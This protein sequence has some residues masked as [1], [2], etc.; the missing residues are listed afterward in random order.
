MTVES[1]VLIVLLALDRTSGLGAP[2]FCVEWVISAF[3]S[4]LPR[5]DPN[6]NVFYDHIVTLASGNALSPGKTSSSSNTSNL[7]E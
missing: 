3:L 1:T 2:C 5:I 6:C 4:H 7:V